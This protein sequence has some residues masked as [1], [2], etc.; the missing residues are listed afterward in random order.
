MRPWYP[1]FWQA[2]LEVDPGTPGEAHLAG[3]R[4][5]HLA[6]LLHQA[7]LAGIES[8]LLTV[9]VDF[10]SFEQW[11][12]PF[13]LGVGPAGA[14][15]AAQSEAARHAIR[16]GRAGRLPAGNTRVAIHP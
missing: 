6:E 15:L 4:E 10:L 5:G 11:W 3:T 7:G 9:S 2:A 8:T 14:Y 13:T 12:E 16:D 1:V